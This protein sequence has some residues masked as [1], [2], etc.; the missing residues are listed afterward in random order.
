MSKKT[1]QSGISF[2]LPM[3]Q[4]QF[5]IDMYNFLHHKWEFID[6]KHKIDT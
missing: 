5:P 1:K 2:N 3:V 6:W 4:V